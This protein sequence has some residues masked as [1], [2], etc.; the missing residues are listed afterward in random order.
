M[1]ED[2]ELGHKVDRATFA[3]RQVAL[4][5]AL[6]AA[7]VE[8]GTRKDLAVAVL[9]NG[10]E[11]GGKSESVAALTTWLDA[12]FVEVNAYDA[13]TDEEREH[14]P[15]W[16]YWRIL[17]PKGR[18]A[19]FFG[20]WY[21]QP[22]VERVMGKGKGRDAAFERSLEEITRFERMLAAEN[23]LLVKAWFHLAKKTQ[24]KRLRALE[25][26]PDTVWRVTKDD[27][28]RFK[29]YDEFRAISE[30]AIRRT[31]QAEAPWTIVD[32]SDEEYRTLVLGETLLSAM[33]AR[34]DRPTDRRAAKPA[35]RAPKVDEKTILTQLD[36][37]QTIT[38]AKYERRLAK[39]QASLA[40]LTR[41]PRFRERSLVVVFEGNDAAGKGGTIRRVTTA[42]DL[43]L[44]RVVPIAA[45]SDEER[46]RP[47]LWRFWRQLPRH[48]RMT[49]FDRS[50]YGRV[51]VERVEGFA[52][53]A[54][55]R[56]AYGE[57]NDFEQELTRHGAI[58]VKFWLA[59]SKEE[60]L[61]RF[62]ERE[63]VAFKQFKITDED[64]RNRKK[65]EDYAAAVCDMVER[66][67]TAIAPWVLVEA[68][69]KKFARVKVLETLAERLKA[70]LGHE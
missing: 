16:R 1:F 68:N 39:A 5:E 11:A 10:V 35:T 8:L 45:P 48:G 17:P 13:P 50:W 31:S 30:R 29:H 28:K 64:W 37:T 41:H 18:I 42:V 66:T 20:N 14:A 43:R 25:K 34:L 65:W 51:L 67:S 38:D 55:W 24:A 6:L 3:K 60:Q 26:D 63:K 27:W 49:I 19:I 12:R 2:A 62:K 53:E 46:A 40:R 59:I 70:E 33:R 22:I 52:A 69:D 21:T 57:I 58:V 54:D 7:Q 44:L 47:Y 36:L 23:V 15:M 61:K 32:G 56:R 9:I 4:R